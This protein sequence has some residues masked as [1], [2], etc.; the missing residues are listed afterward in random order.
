MKMLN[1]GQSSAGNPTILYLGGIHNVSQINHLKTVET[2]APRNKAIK[3]SHTF[4]FYR[5]GY[6][7]CPILM[8]GMFTL[9]N[10]VLEICE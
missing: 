10:E 4:F 6:Q 2:C 3:G 9:K 7:T 8:V 5:W 1:M